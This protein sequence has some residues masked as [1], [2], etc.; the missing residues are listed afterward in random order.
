MNERTR[1]LRFRQRLSLEE[2]AERRAAIDAERRRLL[3]REEFDRRHPRYA[4]VRDWLVRDAGGW[5]IAV[6]IIW[7]L[8]YF[9]ARALAL[10]S[11]RLGY[12]G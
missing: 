11:S 8:G 5:M 4:A 7:I 2:S 3:R 10:W 9:G 1:Q 6:F 12:S